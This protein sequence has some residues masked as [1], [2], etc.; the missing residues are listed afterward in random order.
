[1]GASMRTQKVLS[2]MVTP[3]QLTAIHKAVNRDRTRVKADRSVSALVREW[4]AD[5]CEAQGI[6]WPED[7]NQWGGRRTPQS[8]GIED[9]CT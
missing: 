9:I 5:Y 7:E 1:M 4:F 2:V 8:E 3:Q 6:E